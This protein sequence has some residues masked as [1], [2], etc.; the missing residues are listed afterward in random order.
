MSDKEISEELL[1]EI[2]NIREKIENS[3]KK[4]NTIKIN[5]QEKIK[6]MLKE[7]NKKKFK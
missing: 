3:K 1:K 5:A 2:E 6:T 4:E 7:L